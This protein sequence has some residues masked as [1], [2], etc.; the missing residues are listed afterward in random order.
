MAKDK[1]KSSKNDAAEGSPKPGMGSGSMKQKGDRDS[2]GRF[3]SDSDS[4]TPKGGE[5][6]GGQFSPPDRNSQRIDDDVDDDDLDYRLAGP[7]SR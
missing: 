7:W 5:S 3:S 4:G 2:E 6:R 1:N